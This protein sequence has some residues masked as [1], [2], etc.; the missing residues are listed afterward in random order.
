MGKV[1]TAI[2]PTREDNFPEWYQAVV[3]A[4]QMAENSPVRGC[5]IIKPYGFA[6]WEN[7]QNTLDK[8]IKDCGVQNAYFPLLIPL[9]FIAKEAE[10]IDG[11]ATECAVVTHHRLEKDES[12]KLVPS[13]DAELAEPLV[14]RPTSETIIGETLANWVQSYRDLPM[15]LNQWG[16]V[17]RWEMRPR[18]FLRTSEFLW[19]E[20]HNCFETAEEARAD[21]LTMLDI[22]AYFAEE[23]LAIPVVRGEKTPE[24][25]FPGAVATFTIEAMMQDG[26]ALQSGTSHD[27]GQTFSK[28]ADISFQNQDGGVS[29][30]W[31]T[32][33]GMSTR[34]IGGMLMVHGD[35]DGAMMPPRI[36]PTQ[37]VMLPIL[38][39]EDDL[40]H[41][42]IGYSG[43]IAAM[44]D[45]KGLRVKV[46][47]RDMRN[48]DKIWDS[49]KKGIPVRIEIGPQEMKDQ[50]L[51]FVR[52]DLGRESKTTLPINDFVDMAEDL[53][54]QIHNDMFARAETLL[55][56]NTHTAETAAELDQFYKDGKIGFVDMPVSI[57]QDS[58]FEAVKKA[59]SLSARC[60]PFDGGGARVLIGKSY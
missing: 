24:E 35:D 3:R 39:G 17:M 33:W 42:L 10:H 37:V 54:D 41:D 15:K 30:A 4:A 31:T 34:T 52:R 22:Y 5:M 26:K 45:G 12:G 32:S 51:T 8:M 43:R 55:K 7:I 2:T 57:L 47:D 38:K 56:D 21:S 40:D 60:I 23:Y 6:L 44:L 1:K 9:S 14:V 48:G 58:T 50:T 53:M 19:Q 25:R 49:V 36:A 46:D 59:H 29:H 13:K 11:F 20:G 18:L 28:S 16:N 27:L